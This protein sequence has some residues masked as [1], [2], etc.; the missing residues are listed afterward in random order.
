MRKNHGPRQPSTG[1]PGGPA[2][3]VWARTGPTMRLLSGLPDACST[4]PIFCSL[5]TLRASEPVRLPTAVY[6]S[7]RTRDNERNCHLRQHGRRATSSKVYGYVRV[8]TDEQGRSGLGLAAQRTAIESH[9]QG[10]CWT[11][12]ALHEDVASGARDELERSNT[13]CRYRPTTRELPV[14]TAGSNPN[15][16]RGPV[17]PRCRSSWRVRPTPCRP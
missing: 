14:H 7:K 15:R 5:G 8:S 17:G 6:E 16:Q 3:I 9:V 4:T 10:R 11:L 2:L 1:R 13:A 12:A